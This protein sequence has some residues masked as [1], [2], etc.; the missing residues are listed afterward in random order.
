[1]VEVEVEARGRVEAVGAVMLE[2]EGGR[3]SGGGTWWWLGALHGEAG[4]RTCE[5][6]RILLLVMPGIVTSGSGLR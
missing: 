1:M 6:M 3:R 5:E 2:V 4:G